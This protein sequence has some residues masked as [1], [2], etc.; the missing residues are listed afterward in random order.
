M[1][2]PLTASERRGIIVVAS[3][4]LIITGAGWIV[5]MCQRNTPEEPLPD[6]EVLINGD[7]ISSDTSAV[8]DKKRI[9]RGMRND[10]TKEGRKK[11]RKTFRRRNPLDEGV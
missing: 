8:G 7:S 6:V 2:N 9:R 3:I 5:S 11:S 4:A 10:S 1:R